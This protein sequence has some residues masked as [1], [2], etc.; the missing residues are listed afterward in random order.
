[1]V[2]CVRSIRVFSTTTVVHD[3][4]MH[5]KFGVYTYVQRTQ[6]NLVPLTMHK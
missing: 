2:F 3:I 4:C 5:I 1:M 6:S